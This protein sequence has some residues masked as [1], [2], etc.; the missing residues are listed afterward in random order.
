MDP[1]GGTVTAGR[2][3]SVAPV[4]QGGGL[5]AGPLSI[6]LLGP[7]EVNLE[8]RNLRFGRKKALA[9]LCYL[10]AEGGRR[11][12]RELADFLWP[13]SDQRRARTDL[14]STLAE[15]R[16]T[17]G[18]KGA[19][20]GG[21]GVH[22]L[23][24]DGDLLG[25]EA[26]GVELDLRALEAAVS[27]ARNEPPDTAARLRGVIAHLE[28]ALEAY[29]G[30]FMEGF[31]L[32]DAPEFE[33]WLETERVRWRGVVGELCERLSRLQTGAGRLGEAIRTARLW[34]K[35]APLEEAAHFRLMELLSTVGDA[36]EALMSYQHA[37]DI[38]WRELE[39]EP[40]SRLVELAA[41][42]R[43]EVEERGSLG[44]RLAYSSTTAS[45]PVLDVP[46]TGR[47][48]EFG[49]LVSE[50][51]SCLA[52]GP[53][54]VTMIGEAGIGK[55][56]LAKEFLGWAGAREADVLEGAASESAGVP[57]GPLVE[58]IRPRIE[59]ERAP[60]DLLEDAWLS[61]L[62]RLLPE[63]KERYPDLPSPTS[64][65]GGTAKG[66]LFEAIARTVWV[67]ASRAPVVLF[68]DDSQWADTTTL[69]VLDYAVRRWAEQGAS[70]LVLVAARPE[71]P[72]VD[73]SV[74]RGLPSLVR[75]LPVKSLTLGPLA[76]DEVEG[77]LQR[78]AE[79]GSAPAGVMEESGEEPQDPDRARSELERFAARLA[80]E[81]GGQPFYLIETL[82][83]LLEE[84]KLTVRARPDGGEVLEVG[85]A[86]EAESD[87]GSLLPQSV[88]EVIRSRLSRLSTAGSE[89]LSAG[90]VLGR[91]FGFEALL[92]VAGLGETEGLRGLEE[93][94]ERRLLLEEAG[95][96]EKS[97]PVRFGASYSFSHEKIRQVVHTEGGQARRLVLHRRAFEVLEKGGAPPAELARHALEGGLA[98]EAFEYFVAAGGAAAEV[99]AT[100]D[101]IAHY[102]RARD[103]LIAGRPGAPNRS[104]NPGVAR[105]YAQLGRAYEMAEEH[106]EA[107]TAYE[108]M[109]ASVREAG[110]ARLEVVA[111]NHLAVF[112]FHHEGNLR[113]VTALLEEA[114]KVAEEAGLAEAL[115]ETEC[116]LVDVTALQTGEFEAPGRLAEKALTSA[117]TLDRPDLVARALDALARQ[118]MLAG[119]LKE[120][121]AYAQEGAKISRQLADR[122]AVA[123][124]ELPSMLTGVTGLS[125]S[126]RAGAKALEIQCLI[127]LAYIRIFRGRPQEG[128]TIAREARAIST[129]L[130]ERMETMSLWALGLGFQEMGEYEEALALAIRGTERARKVGYTFLLA[131]NLGR[132]GDAH[133][134]LLNLEKARAAYEEA[135]ALGHY[136]TFSDARLC[137]LA[138][139]SENWDDA[140]AHAKRTH[141]AGT[142]FNPLL[143]I[144]L[145]H[146]VEAL[147]RGGDERLAREEAQ[148]LATRARANER[149]RMSHLRCLAILSEAEGDVEAAIGRLLEAE[150]LAEG[151]GL[152]GELWQIRARIGELHERRGETEEARTAFSA[153]AQTLRTL[154]GKIGD[155]GLREGF[156]SAPRVS[157]VLGRH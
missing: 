111:L 78:L 50:Y 92:D 125:A 97:S 106:D 23:V 35:H 129:E 11:P 114:V 17:L 122:P 28:E 30:T 99:F 130:P 140:H 56:R 67:L 15:V 120:A 151:I 71:E 84:G 82:K 136:T 127:F 153:A 145:H 148:S 26:G 31:S 124:A 48:E 55:T 83:A 22:L 141:E 54:V 77:L 63:L 113:R 87:L 128:M 1:A 85:P 5:G 139:L 73:S 147:L 115:A 61:E 98:D 100:R 2:C 40:S 25:V 64:G 3:E 4:V 89:L 47:Q 62:S 86:L 109:L 9:L 29:R 66:A 121:E 154:A 152:P 137:V 81:T 101:A 95:G 36:E 27:A 68:L 157:R 65:D 146:E 12:R 74:E 94:V 39:A 123:R 69:E 58:A 132:L 131:A 90:A 138:A 119:R 112:S 110:D 107:R 18:A 46:F 37:R 6:K 53:R 49:R 133:A 13:R 79:A 38:L 7:P 91:R 45:R 149:D 80:A 16:K 34:T 103:V 42:L 88:R 72:G 14:R 19:G 21:E 135:V 126:W 108:T 57:Y 20:G 156:L 60:E 143:S 43:D 59:R 144:H 51:H 105:L 8:G 117:R 52:G 150:A 118:G 96:Q 44:A 104:S 102:E 93:L 32:E 24:V 33:S 76:N 75:R 142:F 116:N 70:I 134:A 41:R 155:E 10:A